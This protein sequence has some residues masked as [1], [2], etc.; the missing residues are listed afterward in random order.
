MARVAQELGVN[1]HLDAPVDE[2]L[3]EGKKAVGLRTGGRTV[4]AD[5]VVVNGDF[6][7]TIP[8][9]VPAEKRKTWSNKRVEKAGY[10]CSTFMLYLGIEGTYDDMPH[11]TIFVP[12]TYER[13]LDEIENQHV[14]SENPSVYVQNAC[15]TDPSLAKDGH[16]TL[17]VLVPTT[18]L[19]NDSVDWEAERMRYRRMVLDQ[20]ERMGFHGVR[21][22]IRYERVVTPVDWE[23]QYA[24]HKGAVFN[25]THNIGQMLHNRPRNRFN[26]VEGVYLVGG[27]THPGSGLP[28]IYESARI[29]S[30]LLC[31]DLGLEP[32]WQPVSLSDQPADLVEVA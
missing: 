7:A 4:H 6:A 27:G 30:K 19:H 24:V 11:H 12:K 21:D 13:N 9:L 23:N 10:S 16:S 8:Q 5:A 18:H 1:I 29:S 22:R 15:V 32:A 3:F 28:V 14:L 20:V 31:A 17:Y 25:L 2:V 26:D